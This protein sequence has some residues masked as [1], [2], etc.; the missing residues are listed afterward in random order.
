MS[1]ALALRLCTSV[2]A[3]IGFFML[4]SVVPLYATGSSGG[5]NAAGAATSALMLATVAGELGGPR[6][7][8]RFGSRAVLAVGLALLGAPTLLL[9]ASGSLPWIIA[10]CLV[11]GVGFAFTM[12]AGAALT[13]ALIPVRRRGEGLALAGVVSGVPS[14]LALPLGVWLARHVGYTPVCVATG[15]VTLVS[16]AAVPGL[17][18]RPPRRDASLGVVAGLRS[19]GL[20]R[21][22]VIFGGAAMGAGIIATFL[23]LAVPARLTG[24]V[25]AALFVQ[26]AAATLARW[27]AGRHGDRHGPGGMVIPGVALSAL[28]I[29]VTAAIHSPAAIIVGVALFGL[30]FGAAQNATLTLMY[31]RVPDSGH[32]TVGALWNLAYD[33]GMGIGAAAFGAVI[34]WTGYPWAFAGTAALMAAVLLPAL[35]DRRT[36]RRSDR[37]S[38]SAAERAAE[39]VAVQG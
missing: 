39:P 7:V 14:L 19:G 35:H 1:R 34:G 15:V 16:L 27:F 32:A 4:L 9:T 12:V 22:I 20:L 23:P 31:S 6:L 18:G 11:R 38:A 17:P 10:I 24:L 13:V 26:P 28:G 36:D 29:L 30:G 21:P 33:G 2:G 3:S 5:G 8:A 37:A 25:A